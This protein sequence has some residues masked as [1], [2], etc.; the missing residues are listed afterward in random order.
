[1]AAKNFNMHTNT[2]V[3]ILTKMRYMMFQKFNYR[4]GLHTNHLFFGLALVVALLFS[5]TVVAQRVIN[6][7]DKGTKHSTGNIVTE[8]ATAPTTPT[9]IEGD[10]WLDTTDPTNTLPNVWDGDSWEP[11]DATAVGLWENLNANTRAQLKTLSDGTTARPA[12][13]E[14]VVTDDGNVGVGTATPDASA[15]MEL[16]STSKGFLP[17]R[18]TEAQMDA[19]VSPATGL[20]VYCL[21]CSEPCLYVYDSS[22]WKALCGGGSS[23]SVTNDC[24]TNGFEGTYLTGMAFTSDNKFSVTLENSS[25]STAT[26]SF[27]TTDVSLSG[28]AASGIT[29]SGVSPSSVNLNS[30]DT[31]LIEYSLSGTPAN[32]GTLIANWTKLSLSCTKTKV[33]INGDATFSLPITSNVLSL[34][35]DGPP[36]VDIQGVVDNASNQII[37]NVP[38]TNGI[39]IYEA[40]TSTAVAVTG[41]GGDTNNITISYPAGTFSSSGSIPV[42]VIVDGDGT[43]NVIKQALVTTTTFANLD[44]QVNGNSEGNIFLDATSGIPDREYGDGVHDFI[45][46]PIVGEG[47]RTWLNNNLGADYA[48]SN[49]AS[50]DPT[51]QATAPDDRLAY[52]SL[53]QWGRASDGHELRSNYDTVGFYAET[54]DVLSDSDTPG[55]SDFI[56]TQG[57]VNDDWREPQ[58]PNLWQGENGINNPCPIGYRLPTATELDTEHSATGNTADA[59]ANVLKFSASGYV[60]MNYGALGAIDDNGYLW[61]SSISDEN[62]RVFFYTPSTTSAVGLWRGAGFSVRCIKN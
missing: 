9:P 31:A 53:Y 40:Y 1:M 4:V 46:L 15:I 51:Q 10:I 49:H 52:G 57:T 47:G 13:T 34:H 24:N 50:F 26:I 59:F 37:V 7:D 23:S 58:N 17:P 27:A 16:E 55:H 11:L 30:G 39:G 19:I 44:F 21:D 29:V 61:S 22:A 42:T 41:E 60:S 36:V 14:V 45:Y 25:F 56:T 33:I 2:S 5:S 12:G 43:H 35:H 38:Y 54:T 6:I 28:T 3:N 8:G 48:N 62:S 32:A 20:I 18:M